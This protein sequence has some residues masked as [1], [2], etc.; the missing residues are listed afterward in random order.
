MNPQDVAALTMLLS[1]LKQ[2]STWPFGLIVFSM[3]IGPWVMAFLFWRMDTRRYEKLETGRK[4][5]LDDKEAVREKELRETLRRY[6][7]DVSD[8]KKLYESNSRL[9]V[10][11]NEAFKRLEKRNDELVSVISLNTQTHTQLT[12]AIKNNQ[13]CPVVRSKG[14]FEQ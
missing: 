13:F 14:G 4:K 6:R 1:V 2:M 5:E 10:A 7:E 9:V 3:V 12:A 11:T 8:I